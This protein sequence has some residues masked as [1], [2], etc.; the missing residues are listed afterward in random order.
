MNSLQPRRCFLKTIA[1]AFLMPGAAGPDRLGIMC[2]FDPEE[3]AA[4]KVLAAARSAG[5]RHAQINFPWVRATPGFLRQL[6]GWLVAEDIR[7]D[8]VSAYVNCAVP[9]NVLMD[10]R[11]E[12]LQR[13]IELAPAVGA[14]RLVAWTGGYG[15]GLM[16]TDLR[17]FLPEASDSIRRFLEPSL[18]RLEGNGL[19]L[20][21]ETYITLTCPDGPSLRRLLDRLPT[22]VAAVLDPPNLTPIERYRERDQVLLELCRVLEGRIGLVHLKDFRLA[23]D[24]NS[25]DLPGPMRGEMNYPLLAKQIRQL[26]PDVPWIAEHLAPGE[27]AGAF[28][29]LTAVL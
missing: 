25:Y 8:A 22:C 19:T 13:A 29:E 21:L 10:A 27:F 6:P 1:A 7:A 11:A 2:Q 28:R 15:N 24:G 12:D 14:S 17:N 9:G 18:K 16:T 4:R 20:A 3:S 26:P 23:K 5:Y